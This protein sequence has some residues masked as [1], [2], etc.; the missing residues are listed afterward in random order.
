LSFLQHL[1]HRDR[2]E[3]EVKPV[4]LKRAIAAPAHRGRG[5]NVPVVGM[6]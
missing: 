5:P 6:L 4:R 1:V 3:R 2:L